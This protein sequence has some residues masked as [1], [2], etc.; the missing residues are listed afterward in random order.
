MDSEIGKQEILVHQQSTQECAPEGWKQDHNR[1]GTLVNHKV[2]GYRDS[3]REQK[4]QDFEVGLTWSKSW[5]H[6]LVGVCP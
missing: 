5:L 4:E 2:T 1:A 3:Q 6:C